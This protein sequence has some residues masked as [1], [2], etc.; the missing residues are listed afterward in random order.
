MS[1]VP[2]AAQYI[3]LLNMIHAASVLILEAPL[4]IECIGLWCMRLSMHHSSILFTEEFANNMIK[5][6]NFS[7]THIVSTS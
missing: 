5:N 6:I 1:F 7:H 4:Y 2:A 3:E